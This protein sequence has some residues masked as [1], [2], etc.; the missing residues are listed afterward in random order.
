MNILY[1]SNSG[2]IGGM[3]KHLLDLVSGMS[4]KGHKVFVW[5]PE[6]EMS[7]VYTQAGA[8]V[9]NRKINYEVD[10]KYVWELYRFI[11]VNKID[12]LHA[13]EIKA[14]S[15]ALIA[16]FLSKVKVKITHTHT[17]ISTW[18]INKLKRLINIKIYSLLINFF[19]DKEI[20]LT[21]SVL[22]IKQKEGI[23]TDKLLVIPN[24]IEISQLTTSYNERMLY[25]EEIRKRYSIPQNDFVFGCVGR[26][27]QE[28]GHEVL[29]KAFKKFLDP[30]IFHKRNFYLII[31]GGGSLEQELKKLANDLSISEKVIITG[32]FKEEDKVKFYSAF[33]VFIF[34]SYAEGF[35]LSL[36]EA[37][38][39]SIPTICSDL[40]I[41]KDVGGN[42]VS[43]FKTGSSDELAEKMTLIY[44]DIV[45]NKDLDTEKARMKVESEYTLDI[46][47][48]NYL[49][50]YKSLL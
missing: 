18:K 22:A 15:H 37:M 31:A 40:D 42:F 11:K 27:T 48:N 2:K 44:K 45:S 30:E 3:E 9:L 7:S 39:F 32:V 43:Y 36:A 17:P 10:L 38:Y 13:H 34:P 20:S 16:G 6:G 1:V 49:T 28:K 8:K 29:I 35:G 33:D 23:K 21:R 41:L 12:V 50:L 25:R 19:S 47:T 46:F 24:A 4:S 26:T 5:C 14:V